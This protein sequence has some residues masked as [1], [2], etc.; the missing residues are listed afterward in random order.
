MCEGQ[1]LAILATCI[2]NGSQGVFFK[3]ETATPINQEA[4]ILDLGIVAKK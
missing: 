3:R 4:R 2:Q 1:G